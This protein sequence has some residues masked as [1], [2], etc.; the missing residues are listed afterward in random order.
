MDIEA[1]I[2][3]IPLRFQRPPIRSAPKPDKSAD[4][5]PGVSAAMR[6]TNC[7]MTHA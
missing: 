6:Q 5:Y 2:N 3:G 4:E 1:Y 7:G